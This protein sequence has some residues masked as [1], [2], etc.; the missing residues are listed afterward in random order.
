MARRRTFAGIHA[1]VIVAFGLGHTCAW[2]AEAGSTPQSVA[3]CYALSIGKWSPP[4]ALGEDSKDVA[5]PAVVRLLTT[6]GS[7]GMLVRPARGSAPSIHR[8]SYWLVEVDRVVVVWTTGYSGLR[9]TL[10]PSP[11]GFQGE[12]ESFWDFDHPTQ[13]AHVHATRVG[14][15]S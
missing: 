10:H 4:V 3:G 5:P 14:C 6:R 1:A 11:T 12:A 13:R 9:M 15:G 2:A 8:T 7:E